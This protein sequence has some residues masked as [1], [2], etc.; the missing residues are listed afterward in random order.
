MILFQLTVP[1]L[2]MVI[3]DTISLLYQLHRVQIIGIIVACATVQYAASKL[4]IT[5]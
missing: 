3:M 1:L 4:G 5:A 2:I